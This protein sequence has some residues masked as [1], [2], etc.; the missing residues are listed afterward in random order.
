MKPK[1]YGLLTPRRVALL[2]LLLMTGCAPLQHRLP[3]SPPEASQP[4]QAAC[5]AW[6]WAELAWPI[7]ASQVTAELELRRA[8][9][10]VPTPASPAAPAQ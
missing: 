2:W 3:P 9:A 10:C 4:G 5:T 7:I 6:T 1:I 8:A